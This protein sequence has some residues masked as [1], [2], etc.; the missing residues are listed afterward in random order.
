MKSGQ[1]STPILIIILLLISGS[2]AFCQLPKERPLWPEGI[3]GNPVKYKEEKLRQYPAKT[4]SL[5]KSNR[6]FSCVSSPSF[7]IHT[8]AKGRSNGVAVVICPG[9]GFEDIWIDREGNDLALWLAD[10]GFTSLVLK[11]RTFNSDA[12]G[13][14]LKWE[15][16]VPQVVA[17]ARKAIYFL[18]SEAAS[19]GIDKNKISTEIHIYSK[20]GHG[21]DSGL[22]LGFGIST[23]RDS[24]Y[25]WLCDRGFISNPLF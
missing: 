3:P 5:S 14:S 11:Y 16:Y 8:P 10:K 18:R 22:G 2:S 15:D 9:G 19:L 4:S 6:V 7:I 24:F 12:E 13:F 23:W 25:A 1:I 21:F 17:D 20:G